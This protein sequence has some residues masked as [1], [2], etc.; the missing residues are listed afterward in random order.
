MEHRVA[1]IDM[2]ICHNSGLTKGN[3]IGKSN[4]E[5]WFCFTDGDRFSNGLARRF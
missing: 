1:D 5:L 2:G 4:N 3:S